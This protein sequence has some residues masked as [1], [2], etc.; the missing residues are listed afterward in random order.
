MMPTQHYAGGVHLQHKKCI[1]NAIDELIKH[2]GEVEKA[3]GCYPMSTADIVSNLNRLCNKRHEK[4][5]ERMKSLFDTPSTNW[6]LQDSRT[7][8]ELMIDP[9]QAN[10]IRQ[11]VVQENMSSYARCFVLVIAGMLAVISQ[12]YN[13]NINNSQSVSHAVKCGPKR[14]EKQ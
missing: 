14:I 3:H 7:F 1:Q 4:E 8:P 2:R 10:R 11:A 12:K 6:N 13:G 5:Q 9:A